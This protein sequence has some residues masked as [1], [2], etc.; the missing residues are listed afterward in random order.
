MARKLACLVAKWL[1]PTP[2]D[3]SHEDNE[4]SREPPGL[5]DSE[6]FFGNKHPFQNVKHEK[7]LSNHWWILEYFANLDF[8]EIRESGISLPKKQTF[9]GNRSCD[10]AIQLTNLIIDWLFLCVLDISSN[11]QPYQRYLASLW[12][13]VCPSSCQ[14]KR[15]LSSFELSFFWGKEASRKVGNH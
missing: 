9:G 13:F 3:P 12:W 6:Y 11:F 10:V 2:E 7:N 1:G 14:P 15:L 5:N 4:A 8:P